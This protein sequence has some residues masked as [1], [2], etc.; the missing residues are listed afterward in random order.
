VITP[1]KIGIGSTQIS[2]VNP[3]FT[4]LEDP[5]KA[6]IKDEHN[7]RCITENL[8]DA[9]NVKLKF[10]L[11]GAASTFEPARKSVGYINPS[12]QRATLDNQPRYEQPP[13]QQEEEKLDETREEEEIATPPP[14]AKANMSVCSSEVIFY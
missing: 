8:S 3:L 2:V 10:E 4:A 13:Q 11:E 7:L 1:S 5:S 9:E 12:L 6:L 14:P